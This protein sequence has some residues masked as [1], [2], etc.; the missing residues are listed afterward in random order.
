MTNGHP[1][2]VDELAKNATLL[3]LSRLSQAIVTPLVAGLVGWLLISVQTLQIDVV[4][5][6]AEVVKAVTTSEANNR[7][8]VNIVA[9]MNRRLE[10]LE[11]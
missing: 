10:R 11:K 3:V 7:I 9:D 2:K 4:R 5:V 8:L 6:N 1:H